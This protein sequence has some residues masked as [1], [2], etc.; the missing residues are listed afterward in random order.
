MAQKL[1]CPDLI[2]MVARYISAV[3][4]NLGHAETPYV[5]CKI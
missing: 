5:A 2:E 4:Y 1:L 3:V